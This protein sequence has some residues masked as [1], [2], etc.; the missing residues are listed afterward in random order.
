MC[1]VLCVDEGVGDVDHDVD[2][3]HVLVTERL[4]LH[5]KLADKQTGDSGQQQYDVQ[6]GDGMDIG[7]IGENGEFWAQ[8]YQDTYKRGFRQ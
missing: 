1:S 8:H 5:N 7:I 4:L 6:I 3:G 2:D